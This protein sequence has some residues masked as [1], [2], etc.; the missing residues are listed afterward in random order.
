MK[1]LVLNNTTKPLGPTGFHKPPIAIRYSAV[2]DPVLVLQE[3]LDVVAFAYTPVPHTAN[4]CLST[5]TKYP[6]YLIHRNQCST[7]SRSRGGVGSPV[8]VASKGNVGEILYLDNDE[9]VTLV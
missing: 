6:D 8:P 7:K 1:N 4:P 3:D 9:P 2:L 5:F